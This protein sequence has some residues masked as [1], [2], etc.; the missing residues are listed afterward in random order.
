MVGKGAVLPT[1][2]QVAVST[3]I[4]SVVVALAAGQ[5]VSVDILTETPSSEPVSDRLARRVSA[6]LHDY[7]AHGRWPTDLPLAPS[8]TP[9]QHRVWDCLRRIPT[10]Q[11]RSYGDIAAELGTSARAVGNACRAN[12]IPLFIPC[13]RVVA[14]T[15][16]G[17]FGGETSGRLPAMKAWL[18][19]HERGHS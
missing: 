1:P 2:R 18:L 9:F 6:A 8:G 17:G 15:G 13:H 19:A 10:G 12:P 7:F 11:T 3:P 14:S 5:V 4:G 16:L